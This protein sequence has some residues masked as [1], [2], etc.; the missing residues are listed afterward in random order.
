MY[1]DPTD[2]DDVMADL[3]SI[4][5][6]PADLGGRTPYLVGSGFYAYFVAVVLNRAL[7]EAASERLPTY[8]NKILITGHSLG[9]A[10]ANVAAVYMAN[11]YDARVRRRT[12]PAL[13]LPA[14]V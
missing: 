9:G 4:L 11:K 1:T 13:T 5:S 10:M 2:Y 7:E 3:A 14:R 12:A 8:D 6:L